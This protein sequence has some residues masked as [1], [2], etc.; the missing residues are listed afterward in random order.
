MDDITSKFIK[1]HS[2]YHKI[3]Y[4]LMMTLVL[5]TRLMNISKNSI[6]CYSMLGTIFVFA[7][8]DAI[9]YHTGKFQKNFSVFTVFRFVEFCVYCLFLAFI[10]YDPM[11]FVG[12]FLVLA[13]NLAEF[14]VLGSSFDRTS[15]YIRKILIYVPIFV[16]LSLA[17]KYRSE[18]IWFRYVLCLGMLMIAIYTVSDWIDFITDT[19]EAFNTKNILERDSAIEHNNKLVEY[20]EKVKSINEKV[21]YQKIELAKTINDLEQMNKEVESQK[22]V[23]RYMA[24][25]FDINKNVNV[26]IDAIMDIKNPK[27]CAVYLDDSLQV[28]RY[29]NAYIKTDYSTIERKLKK[30]IQT[31]YKDFQSKP[32]R[33][34]IYTAGEL[35]VFKF[36]ADTNLQSIAIMVLL[37]EEQ[38]YGLLMVGSDDPDFFVNGVNYYE[39]CIV[40]FNISVKSTQLYLKTQDM[41]RKDG[42]TGIYNRVYFGELFAKAAAEAK[43]EDLPIAVALFDID[44][45]KNVNDTY[46]HLVGDK[47]IK[48]VASIDNKYAKRYN[49]FA[50]R[51]GGEEFLLVLP[52]HDEKTAL[53]ILEAMHEEIRN[54]TVQHEDKTLHVNV[55]I[56]LSA[57]PTLCDNTD[58]L[59]NRA[60]KAMYYGKKHGRGRLVVDNPDVDDVIE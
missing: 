4:L 5:L 48:M 53:P 6:L 44:K 31:I 17:L 26:I 60:D 58:V 23:M 36:T 30:E 42:L 19:Y 27:L 12:M 34:A 50:C 1:Y 16:G 52:G 25:S 38:P 46:G 39:T 49:G 55:C 41:A 2:V 33:S 40:E 47:V 29:E 32:N 11:L 10:P 24:S 56:G 15:I 28:E 37:D 45:F 18:Q 13:I 54:T 51:Y 8:L 7:V 35:R 59:V 21:N 3:S 14:I 20:Q 57:Y 43:S 9:L 22:D